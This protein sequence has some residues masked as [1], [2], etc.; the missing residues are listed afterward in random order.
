MQA[1][2]LA[3]ASVALVLIATAPTAHATSR[4]AWATGPPPGPN[5]DTSFRVT[6]RDHGNR[7]QSLPGPE[8][9]PP[10][11]DDTP[12]EVIDLLCHR[13]TIGDSDCGTM[14]SS[15]IVWLVNHGYRWPAERL[16]RL[17][18]ARG[19]LGAGDRDDP[20]PPFRVTMGD[21]AERTLPGVA[22]Y[23]GGAALTPQDAVALFCERHG[24]G[25]TDC[26]RL[27]DAYVPWLEAQGF[28]AP[29]QFGAQQH[30]E[31]E[32]ADRTFEV[33]IGATVVRLPGNVGWP[34]AASE[35]LPR[36]CEQYVLRPDACG[37]V[38]TQYRAW[39]GNLGKERWN[40][41]LARRARSGAMGFGHTR[42]DEEAGDGT[43]QC[44]ATYGGRPIMYK[45]MCEL[46]GGA[47]EK[48][49]N[50]WHHPDDGPE[51]AAG[52]AQVGCFD[53]DS[54]GC[55]DKWD[56]WWH[57]QRVAAFLA[58]IGLFLSHKRTLDARARARAVR[59]R[60]EACESEGDSSEGDSEGS[61]DKNGTGMGVSISLS[62]AAGG[63]G[64]NGAHRNGTNGGEL[65]PTRRR[66]GKATRGGRSGRGRGATVRGGK[67]PGRSIRGGRGRGRG[68]PK[69]A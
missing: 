8:A 61:G 39:L 22:L 45:T 44:T 42:W 47:W 10:G 25:E 30:P 68:K 37:K 2:L 5:P 3:A 18:P 20:E 4:A 34:H 52:E 55:G 65:S 59:K 21:G 58:A 64:A 43:M 41:R 69:S 26:V 31:D 32:L 9:Y 35:L 53:A 7:E 11:G 15:Y 67:S 49:D 13:Y 17:R 57:A 50:P 6:L 46:A 66:R 19:A 29:Q 40:R 54:T 23:L 24:L 33:N 63:N 38:A 16:A 56:L 62:A 14:R 48:L 1:P 51:P 60:G 27:R 28:R 12:D 36:F